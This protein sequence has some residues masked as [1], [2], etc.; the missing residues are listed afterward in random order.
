MTVARRFIAGSGTTRACVPEG[1][2]KNRRA[3]NRWD[4]VFQSRYRVSSENSFQF[5]RTSL[6][7]KNRMNSILCSRPNRV[8]DAGTVDWLPGSSRLGALTT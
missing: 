5:S 8:G 6:A 2:P 4:V 1:R 3:I 7:T